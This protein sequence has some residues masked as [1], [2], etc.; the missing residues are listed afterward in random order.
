MMMITSRGSSRLQLS[1][2]VLRCNH[3]KKNLENYS[4]NKTFSCIHAL[5]NNYKCL[6]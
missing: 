3:T 5:Q 6:T 2:G 1:F 4:R